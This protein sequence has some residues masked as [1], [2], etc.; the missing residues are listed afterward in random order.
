MS[1]PRPGAR[2]PLSPRLWL[3][4]LLP[5]LA[6]FGA[7]APLLWTLVSGLVEQVVADQ[8]QQ[9]LP[10]VA[11]LVR[12][13]LEA[14]AH[15]GA[16]ADLQGLAVRLTAASERRLTI[17]AGDG[18]VLADSAR[19]PDKVAAMDNHGRRPEVLDAVARGRGWAVRR[20]ATTGL[21]YV[22][23]ATTLSGPGGEL[24]VIRLAQ[25]L[26]E[27]ATLRAHLARAL[28]VALLAALGLALALVWWSRRRLAGSLSELLAGV[29]PLEAGRFEHRV[30]AG[31]GAELG[32]LARAFNRMA[33]RAEQRLAEV[34]RQ[35]GR[36][37]AV[38]ASMR[39]G[40]LVTDGEGR[41][42]LVNPAFGRL[43]G[44]RGETA[45]RTPLELTLQPGLQDLVTATLERREDRQT[46]LS[47][48]APFDK[49]LIL[50]ST[51]LRGAPLAA[52]AGRAETTA[53]TVVVVRDVTEAVRLGEMRRDFVANVSHE[54]KTPL[55]AIR[56]LAETLRDETPPV[57]TGA[58]TAGSRRFLDLLL[59]QCGRLEAL[60]DDLLTLSRLESLDGKAPTEAVDLGRVVEES[61]QLIAPRLAERAL[62]LDA[63]RQ[64]AAVVVGDREALRRLLLN[65]LDNAIKYSRP[66]GTIRVRLAVEDRHAVLE[67]A[68]RGIGIPAT[69]LPRI[70]ERFYRVDKGRARD[71][72]GTGLGL[73][74][75]KHA[76]QLHG[77]RVEV[78]SRVG[79]GSTFRVLLPLPPAAGQAP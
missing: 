13:G 21:A 31:G 44:V 56:G 7:S 25:P 72:G 71:Q 35:R 38:L 53:G 63:D 79:E 50:V 64:A 36:L 45:G 46:E 11:S 66:G 48:R 3:A 60:L 62:E 47:L 49:H 33:E 8:L 61:L 55:A 19:T 9:G 14:E 18:L 34:D 75:V 74:I 52:S 10:L 43:F 41:A 59:E 39:D 5:A 15:E 24:Y 76:A 4:F 17:I 57:D 12:D 54:L 70:F 20:S 2:S 78:D 1:T 67:V 16:P 28:A 26:R 51:F 40:V 30:P 42:A 6:A 68:D 23:A 37:E 77:G 32:A 73:A 22:Y 27:L 58:E 29:G 69:A 65:L